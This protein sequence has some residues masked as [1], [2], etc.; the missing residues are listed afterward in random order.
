MQRSWK[1]LTS[2]KPSGM[3][4]PMDQRISQLNLHNKIDYIQ[5]MNQMPTTQLSKISTKRN[6]LLYNSSGQENRYHFPVDIHNQQVNALYDTGAGCSLI[7]YSMYKKT[8]YRPRQG[9]PAHSQV[10]H[11]RKYGSIGVKYPSHSK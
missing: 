11:R 4:S 5:N 2:T 6:R 8:W 7:N 10:I 9:L 3:T 1:Q